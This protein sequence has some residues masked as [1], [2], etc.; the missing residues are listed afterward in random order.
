MAAAKADYRPE[1]VCIEPYPSAYLR[2]AESQGLVRLVV[3]PAQV[4]D[5]DVIADLG[6]DDLLFVEFD[7][8]RQTRQRSEL[9][10]P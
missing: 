1:V 5:F 7:P 3:E 4:V 2:E 9:S 10:D 8:C 6:E